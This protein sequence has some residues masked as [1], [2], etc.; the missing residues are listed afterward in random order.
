[1]EDNKDYLK[2]Y[3]EYLIQHIGNVQK[4]YKILQEV[5]EIPEDIK[6]KLD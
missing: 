6:A 3:G 1:M 4:A 2:K 5:V